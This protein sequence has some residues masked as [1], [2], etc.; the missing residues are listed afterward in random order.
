MRSLYY[1]SC[2]LK[3][4]FSF[5]PHL[6]ILVIFLSFKFFTPTVWAKEQKQALPV[7]IASSYQNNLPQANNAVLWTRLSDKRVLAELNA[8]ALLSP[9]SLTKLITAAAAFD[10]YGPSFTHKTPVMFTGERRNG[11]IEGDLIFVGSGDPYL[12]SEILWQ[13]AVDLK[14]L[15]IK[16]VKGSLIVDNSLF[17]DE[18]RDRSR[19]NSAKRSQNAYDAPI[20]SFSVNFNTAAV[21]IAPHPSAPQAYVQLSPSP[22]QNVELDAQVKTVP[23]KGNQDLSVDRTSTPTGATKLSVRG[24]IGRD[25]SLKKIYRSVS[26]GEETSAAYVRYFLGEQGIKINGP[27]KFSKTPPSAKLLHVIEGYDMRKVV[28]GLNV[29]SNNFIADMVTKRLSIADLIDDANPASW[30]LSQSRTSATLASG[31]KT[32]VSFLQNQVGIKGSFTIEN[33]SGL[34]T[35]NRL[36]AKHISQLLNWVESQGE[37][38]PDFLGTLPANGLDGTMRRRKSSKGLPLGLI[39][40]KTGTLTEPLSVCGIAGYFRHSIHGWTSFVILTNG[41]QGKGQPSVQAIRDYQDRL[42]SQMVASK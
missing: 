3:A 20:H 38:F 12:V 17:D 1:F 18:A 16:E 41:I 15:G 25:A 33:G 22:L 14:H 8:D 11:V 26:D 39:R 34:D 7:S 5:L 10:Q 6:L 42:L 31:S 40:A 23:G 37:M 19:T 29:F 24:T 27:T 32:L 2:F 30:A 36:S 4:A 35:R 21:A 28:S 9:A 13:A